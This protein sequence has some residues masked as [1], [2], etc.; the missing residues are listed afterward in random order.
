MKKHYLLAFLSF[1][2]STAPMQAQMRA[3]RS[4]ALT[5]A[6][7]LMLTTTTGKTFYYLVSSNDTQMMY[8][9]TD[10][11]RIGNDTFPKRQVKSMRF[12]ALPRL[13]MD[14]DSITFYRYQ[15]LD[16]GLVALRRTMQTGQWNS[17]VL[18]FDLTGRQVREAF[19]DDAQL[20]TVKGINEEYQTAV[21]FETIDLHTDDRALRANYHYLIRP[22]KEP[23]VAAT[24]SL[25]GFANSRVKGPIYLFPNVN[26]K[27][28]Q[29]ARYQTL[30]SEDETTQVR[31]RGTYLRLDGSTTANK[32]LAP[33]IYTFDEEEQHT[34][35]QHEDSVALGAFRSWIQDLSAEPRPLKFYVDGVDMTDGIG[36]VQSKQANAQGG[37]A[38]YDLS[39]RSMAAPMRK[40]LYIIN[41]RKV[42]IK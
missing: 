14:E 18:P 25:S 22:T 12:H 7:N 40:G 31:F 42:A 26:M 36:E 37:N 3:T 15:T 28:N 34:F 1:V 6:K 33:S 19:G 4:S 30:T 38:V 16:Y 29:S 20:A 13:L 10:S 17:L 27:S 2:L 32:K 11:I 5:G 39:G 21:E 41:G 24:S 8:L 23:D 9:T 35:V